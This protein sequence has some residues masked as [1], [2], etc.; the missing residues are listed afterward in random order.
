[1]PGYSLPS[2]LDIISNG[3]SQGYCGKYRTVGACVDRHGESI[4]T[5]RYSCDSRS[6]PICYGKWA[7]KTGN[8]A[9]E[10][11]LAYDE[12]SNLMCGSNQR[13]LDG[14]RVSGIP[15]FVHPGRTK[16]FVFS[17]PQEWAVKEIETVSGVRALRRELYHVLDVAGMRGA[18]VV[19]HHLRCTDRAKDEFH[20]AKDRKDD[21]SKNGLWHWLIR[22]GL[23]C[24][25]DYTYLSPHFHVI[26]KGFLMKSSDFHKETVRR[27]RP[28]WTYKNIRNLDD[29]KSLTNALFYVLG[30]ACIVNGDEDSG[31][32]RPL[33]CLTYYGDISKVSMGHKMENREYFDVECPKCDKTVYEWVGWEP[34]E[35]NDG[36]SWKWNDEDHR[37]QPSPTY[38]VMIYRIEKHRY[39]MKKNDIYFSIQMRGREPIRDRGPPR[40]MIVDD[41]R[42]HAFDWVSGQWF[43]TDGVIDESPINSQIKGGEV[44]FNE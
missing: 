44:I 31:L 42:D 3:E 2:G 28:G 5:V 22:T 12:I 18:A 21:N 8:G 35:E 29:E 33:D 20:E 17:P 40:E 7:G 1:M 9:K 27:G 34:I 14:K 26:G 13:N 4:T 11:L 38:D 37:V 10:R 36:H 25:E 24:H 6:C 30:H 39:W 43:D 15:G 32:T 41:H 23:V 16:H 19:F